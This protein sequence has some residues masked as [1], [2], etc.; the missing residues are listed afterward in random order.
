MHIFWAQ[1]AASLVAN[2]TL[3]AGN[4]NHE[5]RAALIANILEGGFPRFSYSNLSQNT[6]THPV[7]G[8]AFP[9][10]HRVFPPSLGCSCR[11]PAVQCSSVNIMLN[12]DNLLAEIHT[13]SVRQ[14]HRQGACRHFGS[15]R[16]LAMAKMDLHVN[17]FSPYSR[18][19]FA[20]FCTFS[21]FLS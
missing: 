15:W 5:F 18:K 21:R 8:P 3:Q 20:R 7:L 13:H 10:F 14:S 1:W 2:W 6:P 19:F 9:A 16:V 11:L 17:L 4:Y 12:W